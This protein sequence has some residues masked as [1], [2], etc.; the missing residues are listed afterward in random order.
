MAG[1]ETRGLVGLGEES[2]LP[3]RREGSPRRV[4]K[5]AM[6]RAEGS[7]RGRGMTVLTGSYRNGSRTMVVAMTFIL[8]H[9]NYFF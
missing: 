8:S 4:L 9:V 6:T 5:C 2:R 1:V 3:P 7:W